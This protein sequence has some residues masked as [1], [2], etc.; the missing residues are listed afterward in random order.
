MNTRAAWLLV[1]LATLLMFAVGAR[2]GTA[3]V[4]GPKVAT[5]W[6]PVAGGGYTRVVSA[7]SDPVSARVWAA[8]GANVTAADSV[9]LTARAGSMAISSTAAVGL[10][11][12]ALAVARCLVGGG[13]AICAVGTAAAAAYAAYRVYRGSAAGTADYDPGQASQAQS[14]WVASCSI[15]TTTATGA[16]PEAAFVNA[17]ATNVPATAGNIYTFTAPAATCTGT[18]SSRSCSGNGS[19]TCRNSANGSDC[20]SG[21]QFMNGSASLQTVQVCPAVIDALNP[22]EDYPGGAPGPDGKCPSA[23][24]NH[25][26]ISADDAKGKVIAN[27]PSGWPSSTWRDAVRDSIDTGGQSAPATITTT[28]PASQTGTPTTTTT[29]TSSGTTTKTSTPTYS[30]TYNG[31]TIT[32]N[33]SNVT[34]TNVNGTVTETTTTTDPAT[35]ETPDDP[36]NKN[37]GRAGCSLLGTPDTTAPSWTN[38]PI[39]FST[40]DLGLGSGSCPA[41]YPFPVLGHAYTVSFT[42]VCDIAPTIRACMIALTALTCAFFIIRGVQS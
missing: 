11:D 19:Y 6:A 36:C 1:V 33:T 13:P 32:Y 22:G 29:T 5:G 31:D 7:F 23:R 18:G 42:P 26:P 14:M 21:T 30:Y 28:G 10:G 15:G 4:L 17:C 2:A 39:V 12:G 27:P 37:P 38:K 24:Y 9:A 41:P 25:G 20:G 40:E 8:A 34:V 3:G 35:A 16:S